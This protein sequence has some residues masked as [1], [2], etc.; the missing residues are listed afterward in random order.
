MWKSGNPV[1]GGGFMTI[2]KRPGLF[3]AA[4]ATTAAVIGLC[5]A[6]AL[7]SSPLGATK[8]TVTVKGGGKFTATSSK[9]VLTQKV[10]SVTVKVTCTS[11]GKTP[12][13]SASG[14]I[15][16]GTNKGNSP[17]Q[18]GTATNLKFNNCTGPL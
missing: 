9:T 1:Q 18:V 6:P 8:L 15:P 7:A 11:K 10:G 13:S 2:R 14:N 3:F 16:N 17:V 12:A 5:A 4:T